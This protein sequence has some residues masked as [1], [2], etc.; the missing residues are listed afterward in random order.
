MYSPKSKKEFLSDTMAQCRSIAALPVELYF[1]GSL[2]DKAAKDLRLL[3]SMS[4]RAGWVWEFDN[5]TEEVADE[6]FYGLANQS[7]GGDSDAAPG[8]ADRPIVVGGERGDD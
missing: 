4:R 2:R 8:E 7:G 5:V 6:G 1:Q 3:R